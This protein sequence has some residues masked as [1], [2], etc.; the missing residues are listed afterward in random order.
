M[1]RAVAL[2]RDPVRTFLLL[3]I[4]VGGY[5]VFTVPYFGGIDEPAHFWQLPDLDWAVRSREDRQLRVQWRACRTS[6]SVRCAATRSR[7]RHVISLFPN[8]VRAGHARAGAEAAACV[9]DETF[10]TFSTFRSPVPYLPQAA[11]FVASWEQRRRDAD[12][13]DRHARGV[14]GDRGV[15]IG[16]ARRRNGRW[17]RWR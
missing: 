6:S 2:F 16:A 12:Q 13:A 15:A 10:V 9:E 4:V 14:R 8:A 17:A 11:M 7:L 3:A 1:T 5:L